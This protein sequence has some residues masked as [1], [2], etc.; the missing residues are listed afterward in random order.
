MQIVKGDRNSKLRKDEETHLR[1]INSQGSMARKLKNDPQSGAPL[2]W[3]VVGIPWLVDNM[4]VPAGF[5]ATLSQKK[6]MG[7]WRGQG[8]GAKDL[9]EGETLM[10][11]TIRYIIAVVILH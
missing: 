7:K 2:R 3:R 11:I 10:M 1:K 4:G 6:R 5:H 9:P 8:S